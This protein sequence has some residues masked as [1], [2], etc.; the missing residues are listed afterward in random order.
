[1][2]INPETEIRRAVDGGKVVFGTTQSEKSILKGKAQLIII[3]A[4][5]MA[6]AKEKLLA[7]SEM[8][9][10]PHFRYEGTGKNLGSVCGKPF[11]VS[12]MAVENPGKSKVLDIAKK[13]K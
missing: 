9:E 4:N 10:I 8:A 7:L 13:R 2:E 5:I 3:S 12:A 1:M 6:P 11:T